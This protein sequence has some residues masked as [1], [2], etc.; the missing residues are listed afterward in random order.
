VAGQPAP[1]GVAAR[2][3]SVIEYDLPAGC[4]RFQA[5]AGLDD[6]GAAPPASPWP[7][8]SVRFMV[9]T[10][11][12]YATEASAAVPV[13]LAELGF[14]GPCRIR[15]LWQ[16]KDF[17]PVTGEFAPI[18]NAHGAGLYCVSAVRPVSDRSR[19]D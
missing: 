2:P 8:P 5:F 3:K 15:D 12:P 17:D 16:K 19:R 18:I 4:T 11:S 7:A 9:F 10:Q 6:S 1:F 13:K 14:G